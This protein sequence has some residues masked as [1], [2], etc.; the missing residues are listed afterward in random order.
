MEKLKESTFLKVICHILVPILIVVLTLS[1]TI[2]GLNNTYQGIEQDKEFVKSKE[3]CQG[4]LSDI[5]YT[6]N[7]IK[8]SKTYDEE[9]SFRQ[10]EE[11]VYY[12][13]YEYLQYSSLKYIKYMI[14]EKET[15]DIYTNIQTANYEE[16]IG[17]IASNENYWIY[18]NGEVKTNLTEINRYK[19]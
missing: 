1:I 8:R 17:N 19:Q 14:K 7:Y 10:I 15:G 13:R 4:Y 5:L 16:Y 12:Q 6:V 2:V 9:Y 18:E 11:N 3:F